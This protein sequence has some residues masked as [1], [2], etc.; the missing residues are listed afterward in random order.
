MS[1]MEA[2]FEPMARRM[3]AEEKAK[4]EAEKAQ[5]AQKAF[6]ANLSKRDP[7]L[8]Q[9][10]DIT[11]LL[12]RKKKRGRAAT[13]MGSGTRMPGLLSLLSDSRTTLLG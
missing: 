7:V 8:V 3:I 1:F 9:V 13:I 6:E 5:K 12:R 4:K 2:I 11:S 10:G